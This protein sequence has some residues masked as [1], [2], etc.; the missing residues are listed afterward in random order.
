MLLASHFTLNLTQTL[1]I[2]VHNILPFNLCVCV[3]FPFSLSEETEQLLMELFLEEKEAKAAEA[4][5]QRHLKREAMKKEMMEANEQQKAS[6]L[7]KEAQQAKEEEARL[8]ISHRDSNQSYFHI[9][10]SA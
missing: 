5:Q 2:L 1:A 4:E 9:L 10:H 7:Q 8:G 3:S 6:R